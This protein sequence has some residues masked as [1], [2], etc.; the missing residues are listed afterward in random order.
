MIIS[1]EG[2]MVPHAHFVQHSESPRDEIRTFSG[3]E[4]APEF[5]MWHPE[6]EITQPKYCAISYVFLWRIWFWLVSVT[7]NQSKWPG[8][9]ARTAVPLSHT[10]KRE[11]GWIGFQESQL[12][13]NGSPDTEWRE[14]KP[15][16]D[17]WNLWLNSKCCETYLGHCSV[18]I[19]S[20]LS[21]DFPS[22]M[23][24]SWDSFLPIRQ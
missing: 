20:K 6:V 9:R 23:K 7:S 11:D 13:M 5:I 15:S 17:C 22:R 2:G 12:S 18:G 14:G 19:T 24:N 8:S 3:F 16:Y 1:K 21:T 10:G 4:A